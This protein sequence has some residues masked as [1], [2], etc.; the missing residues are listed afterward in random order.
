MSDLKFD[1]S[2]SGDLSFD[3]VDVSINQIHKSE[4]NSSKVRSV[5]FDVSQLEIPKET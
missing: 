2:E 1:D 5:K 4:S 3:E